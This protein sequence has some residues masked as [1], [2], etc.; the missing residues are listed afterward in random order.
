[1]LTITD[2]GGRGVSQKL[3]NDH[4]WRG[5][6]SQMLTIADKAGGAYLI[7]V[8]GPRRKLKFLHI[9]INFKFLHSQSQM[10]WNLKF[11]ENSNDM[12][13]QIVHEISNEMK[14][15]MTWN[16]KLHEI[17]NDMKSHLTLNVMKCQMLWNVKS[18]E[19]S[20]DKCH[21]MTNVMKCQTSWNVK[22]HEMSNIMKRQTSWNVKSHEMSKVNCD[23]IT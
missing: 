1:M 13:S 14:T 21:E 22:R 3:T 7:F 23:E 12:K 19:M 9:W 16:V 15:Q 8:T 2:E 11:H 20:N 10:T 4:C 17:S 5:G 18:H 6:V